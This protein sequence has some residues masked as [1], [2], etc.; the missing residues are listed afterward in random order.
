[1][2]TAVEAKYNGRFY[3]LI[4]LFIHNKTVHFPTALA[5]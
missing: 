4:Y 3:L 2:L 1:M 5:S